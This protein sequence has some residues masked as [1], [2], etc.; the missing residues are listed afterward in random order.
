MISKRNNLNFFFRDEENVEHVKHAK[1]LQEQV[2]ELRESLEL[3]ESG[4]MQF[5][6]G[7]TSVFTELDDKRAAMEKELFSAKV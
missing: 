5:K 7:T 4:G 3:A 2:C 1:E 6:T